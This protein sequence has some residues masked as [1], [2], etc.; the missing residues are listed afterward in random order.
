MFGPSLFRLAV[1]LREQADLDVSYLVDKNSFILARE[2]RDEPLVSD[3]S[4]C[5]VE[6]YYSPSA[7]IRPSTSLLTSRLRSFDLVLM[8]DLGPMFGPSLDVPYVFLPAGG[9]LTCAPFPL[10]SRH[11]RRSGILGS[12]GL[13]D[14]LSAAVIG[15][16]M[17]RGISS[18]TAVWLW[19]GPF[20]PYTLALDR[21]GLPHPTNDQCL[22]LAI[23]TTIFSPPGQGISRN[24]REE[25]PLRVFMPSRLMINSN[26]FLMETGQWKRNDV[27]IEGVAKAVNRG[28][29]LRLSLLTNTVSGDEVAARS[30]IR[31]LGIEGIVD[32]IEPCHPAGF[33]WHQL[34]GHYRRADVVAD[35]FGAGWFGTVALEAA[36]CG[37]SVFNPVDE[38]AMAVLYK[39][40]HPFITDSS[41]S[42]IA[43]RLEQLRDPRTRESIG[44]ASA[45][46]AHA[47]HSTSGVGARCR[48]MVLDLLNGGPQSANPRSNP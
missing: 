48:Q 43:T 31:R 37:A 12:R 24:P 13:R 3:S 35:D 4:F 21:L 32:W 23:D 36:A 17:R 22:P 39:D 7:L 10:R 33:S 45:E 34:A 27:F 16:S 19:S 25:C 20:R 18:A 14:A 47:H 44:K 5:L 26:Q 1:G 6:H 41:A 2:L 38:A 29:D 42:E 15:Q 28:V 8:A 11:V 46:W 40:G 30:M 9:D